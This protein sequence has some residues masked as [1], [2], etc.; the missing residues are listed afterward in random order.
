MIKNKKM[1]NNQVK[2]KNFNVNMKFVMLF[3]NK[4]YQDHLNF[5]QVQLELWTLM[6]WLKSDK[7]TKINKMMKKNRLVKIR[8]SQNQIR[9]KVVIVQNSDLNINLLCIVLKIVIIIITSKKL[10]K[11]KNK[12]S[13]LKKARDLIVNIQ[14]N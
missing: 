4:F 14:A 9:E 13:L 12:D 3:T 11:F 10:V 5:I 1:K 8:K 7:V 6:I 2:L